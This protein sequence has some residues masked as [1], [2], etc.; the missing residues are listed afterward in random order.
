MGLLPK[1]GRQTPMIRLGIGIIY[2]LLTLGGLTMVY[3][4]LVTLTGAVSNRYDYDRYS[5]YPRYWFDR[6]ERYLKYLCEEYGDPARFDYFRNAYRAPAHWGS[7][8]DIAN[9]SNPLKYFP[10]YG[11]ENDPQKW[12]RLQRIAD[13]YARFLDETT[14][15][16]AGRENVVP[17]FIRFR[18]PDFRQFI[19]RR[20]TTVAREEG[21]GDKGA[22]LTEAALR[23]M[24]AI[25]GDR[26]ETF[27]SVSLEMYINSPMNLPKWFPQLSG[28]HVDFIDWLATLQPTDLLPVTRRYL[29]WSFLTRKNISVA[30]YNAAA[31]LTATP[32]ALPSLESVSYPSGDNLS[33]A[34]ATLRS[35]FL[36]SGWPVR[37]CRVEEP[38]RPLFEASLKEV[39]GTVAAMNTAG[40]TSYHDWTDVPLSAQLPYCA[41]NADFRKIDFD[42]LNM[43]RAAWRVYVEKLLAADSNCVTRIFPEAEY[44]RFL[45]RTY[46]DLAAINAAYDWHYAKVSQI[47]LPVTQSDYVHYARHRREFMLQ[48]LTYNYKTVFTFLV[49]KG[50]AFFNTLV[51]VALTIFATLTVN[52]LAAYALSR[53][54]LRASNQILV[55]LLATMAFPPEVAMIPSFLL[56][57][58]F[59]L[60]NTYWA[61]ILPRLA[62]GF[63][64]FL[65]KGF[66]DSLPKE[67]YEAASIDGATE[68][69]M[70]RSITLPL[71]KPILAVIALNAFIQ[72]YG[73][74]MWAFLSC[75]NPK[76]WTLMVFLYQFQQSMKQYPSMV[77][78]ALVLAS[79]P[80][81]LVFMFCQKIIL[82]GIIIPTM[83]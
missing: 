65:L 77:M 71:C 58:D 29:W 80:T 55:I 17:L 36:R 44:Q 2:L 19:A 10:L 73:G 30:D 26:Y 82:R 4:F 12:E 50:R 60:L 3:P 39:Y 61:L 37:L 9:E 14:S 52:P 47:E 49:T 66:F 28:R 8:R 21:C 35:E 54:R 72:A 79:L 76:M 6:G 75:Q 62:N 46:G 40:G 15:T 57:R 41:E 23:C 70:F 24:A 18:T 7:F 59:H 43:L 69:R 45:Q 33:P 11:V 27:D 67:L 68:A 13:D 63:S 32:R 53:F 74:F 16:R 42:K 64:I 48:F 34:L 5:W 31:G 1:V 25:R 51:L 81:L 56:L 22:T 83:K 20:Y 78:A 38:D